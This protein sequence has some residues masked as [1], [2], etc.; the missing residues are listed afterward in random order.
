MSVSIGV[1]SYDTKDL[2]P[3]T[4]EMM[5]REVDKQLYRAKSNGR[6]CVWGVWLDVIHEDFRD[7]PCF[8]V[9]G[10]A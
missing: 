3:T 9:F 7:I 6:N 10:A 4:S 1:V 5:L 8:D 2:G